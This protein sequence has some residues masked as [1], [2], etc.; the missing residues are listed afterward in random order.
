[1]ILCE[2]QC[3]NCHITKDFL[4]SDSETRGWGSCSECEVGTLKR[5]ISAPTLKFKGIGFYCNDYKKYDK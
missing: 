1:M 5:I 3:N 4:V 2:F